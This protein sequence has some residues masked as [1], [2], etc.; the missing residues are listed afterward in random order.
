MIYQVNHKTTYRYSI[1]VSFSHHL[2]HLMP[3]RCEHQTCHRVIL[4]LLPSPSAKTTRVDY[5]GNPVI[6][7]TLQDQHTQLILNARSVIEVS[8]RPMPAPHDSAPWDDIYPRLYGDTSETGLDA[9]QY[10][11]ASP[12]TIARTDLAGFARPHFPP[13]RPVLEGALDLT[14]DIYEN[15]RYDSFATTV[16]TP[17]DEVF[18]ARHG[19]CQDFAHLQ[20]ACLRALKIPARYVSGYLLTRP[21]EGQSRLIGA[22]ASHAWLS[23][24]CPAN[25]WIDID[26]TNNLIVSDEHITLTWGRDYGDVSPITGAIFGGGAH[27]IEVAVDVVPKPSASNE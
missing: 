24:W 12:Y 27:T 6:D 17:V 9:I 4:D 18:E 3:R 10:V 20:I 22:D 15:F 25:G 16:S 7:I 26:P 23:V 19:V 11:F 2:L 8:P 21:P 1:P 14:R 5:F 13:G